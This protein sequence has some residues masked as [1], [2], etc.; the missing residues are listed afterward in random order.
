MYQ[1]FK[2]IILRGEILS[3]KRIKTSSTVWDSYDLLVTFITWTHTHSDW[4][5]LYGGSADWDTLCRVSA[6]WDT[7][8][9]P[10]VS[11]LGHTLEGFSGPGHTLQRFSGQGH[12]L[13]TQGLAD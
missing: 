8:C 3:I 10:G 12:T 6:D 1:L 13:Q 2:E 4:D 9:R 7:L 11:G 5:N